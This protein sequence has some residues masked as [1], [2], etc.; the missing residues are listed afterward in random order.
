MKILKN[1][2]IPP[3]QGEAGD[4]A[5]LNVV[6]RRERERILTGMLRATAVMNEVINSTNYLT[7]LVQELLDQAQFENGRLALII[8]SFNLAEMVKSVMTQLIPRAEAKG[9]TLT[10]EIDPEL[11][12]Y[13]NG[14]V[15]RLQQILYNL[16]NN[17]IKFTKTGTV[18]VHLYRSGPARWVI[19]VTDTGIGIPPDIQPYVFEPFRQGDG[20]ITREYEGTGLGLAIVKQLTALMEGEIALK[21]EVGQGSTFTVTLPLHLS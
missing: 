15:K 13:L 14:D 6:L 10:L 18:Q 16:I 20:S 8:T 17:A 12:P 11:P 4:E 19:E 5:N 21:S 9:L 7:H 3:F 1:F 2:F